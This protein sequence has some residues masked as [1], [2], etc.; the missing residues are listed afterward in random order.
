MSE[1]RSEGAQKLSWGAGSPK[2][3]ERKTPDS[4]RVFSWR[5]QVTTALATYHLESTIIAHCGGGGMQ[6]TCTRSWKTCSHI[7]FFFTLR[8]HIF[9]FTRA[10]HIGEVLLGYSQKVNKIFRKLGDRVPPLRMC[11]REGEAWLAHGG[12]WVA[13]GYANLFYK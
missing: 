1:G 13:H 9:H 11:G 4:E 10:L 12:I 6:G 8:L 7:S 2:A 5:K 3:G